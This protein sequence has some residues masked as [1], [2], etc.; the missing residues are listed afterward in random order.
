[1]R[2]PLDVHR[3]LLAGQVLHEMVHLPRRVPT[4]DEVPE[5]VD[6]PARACVAMR[7]YRCG[8]QLVAVAVPAG[9]RPDLS[10]LHRCLPGRPPPLPARPDEVS[11]ATDY[12]AA[13]AGP[14]GLPVDLPL[15]LD[16]ALTD[17]EVLY[18]PA[19]DSATVVGIRTRD[20]LAIT[21]AR[22]ARLVAAELA[23]PAR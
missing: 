16:D 10:A 6:L 17:S 4:A 19:G 5:V 23:T 8:D 9:F 20:L 2:G 11:A 15:L 12:A 13:L 1:M 14:L 21:G 3:E 22:T 7:F 18:C